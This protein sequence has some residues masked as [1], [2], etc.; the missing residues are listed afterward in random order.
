MITP[1]RISPALLVSGVAVAL[2]AGGA[3]YAASGS[4]PVSR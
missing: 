2:A 3:G 1:F 4:S